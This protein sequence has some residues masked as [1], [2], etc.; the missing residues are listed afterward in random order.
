MKNFDDLKDEMKEESPQDALS[1]QI[2]GQLMAKRDRLGYSQRKLAELS[3]VAQK[4]ISRV[5]NGID[6]PSLGTLNRLAMA[7]GFEIDLIEK[8]SKDI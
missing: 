6:S 4:T 1:T 8:N 5:E 3:G 7:L 2:I